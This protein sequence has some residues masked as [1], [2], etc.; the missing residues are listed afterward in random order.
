MNTAAGKVNSHE[1]GRK[2]PAAHRH[3][4][5]PSTARAVTGDSSSLTVIPFSS[6]SPFP[7]GA[8]EQQLDEQAPR[9]CWDA[10]LAANAVIRREEREEPG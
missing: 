5:L 9:N 7:D 6:P 8:L 2:Q 4:S 10:A 3:W 1:L